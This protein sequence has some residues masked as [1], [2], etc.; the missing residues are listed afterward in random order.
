MAGVI[1]NTGG[2]QTSFFNDGG[3][4]HG[5]FVANL[6]VAGFVILDPFNVKDSSTTI[7]QGNQIGAPLKQASVTKFKTATAT[8]QIP[9]NNGTNFP[10]ILTKG[11][12]FTAPVEFGG[13]SWYVD[14]V[15]IT[16]ASGQFWKAEVNF[17]KI[18]NGIPPAGLI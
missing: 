17:R 1:V 13:E 7:E 6:N 11:D 16:Y 9:V 2:E 14:D 3:V 12:Y 10:V 8:A 18:Y 5:G 4:G 15:G